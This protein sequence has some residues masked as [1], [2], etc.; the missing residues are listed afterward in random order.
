M[1]AQIS[2]AIDGP[3][4]AGK[5]TLAKAIAAEL[6]YIYV[7]TGA[8]YRTVGLAA[9]QRGVEP[10]ASPEVDKLL[11]EISVFCVVAEK[12]EVAACFGK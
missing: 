1:K 5:S 7:D 12:S 2:I 11:S 3:S 6:N 9:S 10:V 8:L 4:G